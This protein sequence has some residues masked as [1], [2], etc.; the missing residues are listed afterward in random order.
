MTLQGPSKTSP[1]PARVFRAVVD[2][3]LEL[4]LVSEYSPTT[5]RKRST[6]GR[7]ILCR[8]CAA[9]LCSAAALFPQARH[10]LAKL[11]IPSASLTPR[12]SILFSV[13]RRSWKSEAFW[14]VSRNTQRAK[15][16]R[17]L[18]RF[19]QGSR[20][21]LVSKSIRCSLYFWGLWL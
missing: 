6:E 20:R 3:R 15:A 1:C 21:T 11:C 12:A 5:D 9:T 4:R 7:R 8:W 16:R 2:Q 10:T 17:I 18:N 13:R 14:W 19:R